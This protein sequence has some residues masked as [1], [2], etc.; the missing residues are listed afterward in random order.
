MPTDSELP[1]GV[2]FAGAVL[3]GML[4][5]CVDDYASLTGG[6]PVESVAVVFGTPLAVAGLVALLLR[7]R[8]DTFRRGALFVGGVAVL[9]SILEVTVVGVAAHG[10]G[11][12]A[13]IGALATVFVASALQWVRGRTAA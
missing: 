2:A 10:V 7:R 11:P 8:L 1:F 9:V 5:V 3:V 4:A 12:R 13:A 6:T